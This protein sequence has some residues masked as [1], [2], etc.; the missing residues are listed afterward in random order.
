MIFRFSFLFVLAAVHVIGQEK[1]ITVVGAGLAGLSAAHRIEKMTGTSVDVYEARE[2]LGGRVYTVRLGHHYEELG[3]KSIS[4]GGNGEN[5]RGLIEEMGLKTETYVIDLS[6][7]RYYYKGNTGWYYAPLEIGLDPTPET[8]EQAQKWISQ[9]KCLGEV[10]DHFF[11]GKPLLRHLAEMRTRGWEGSDS[12]DLSTIYFEDFWTTYVK[13]CASRATRQ[14]GNYVYEYVQGGNSRL[15]EQLANSLK[16]N[17]YLN[18]P[19]QEISRSSDGRLRLQFEDGVETT[20]DYLILAIPCSTLRDVKIESGLLPPDQKLAIESLHYGSNAKILLPVAF[21]TKEVS[22]FST[23]NNA[24]IWFNKESAIM[25]FYYGGTPGRFN[26]DSPQEVI[27]KISLE[28]D[29]LQ[30]LYPNMQFHEN[31]WAS[32]SWANEKFSKGSY[33][34]WGVNQFAFFD[35]KEEQ[36]G[37]TVRS[38]FRPIEDKIFFAGEHATLEFTG[39]MEGAVESGERSARMVVRSLME[40]IQ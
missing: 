40:T 18:C 12:H 29:A 33:S 25:T 7:R 16:G 39:T 21:E 13:I 27:H 15:I 19:L 5:I 35:A 3:G 20:T 30:T 37:E 17:I 32:I 8:Y 36:F 34:S 31:A 11:E 10:L 4:D 28:K 14:A 22:S 1:K 23:T 6:K 38:V 2:R 24:L 9:A 26:A